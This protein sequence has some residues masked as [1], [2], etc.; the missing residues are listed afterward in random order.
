MTKVDNNLVRGKAVTSPLRLYQMKQAGINQ[1]IDLRNT[2]FVKRPIE[3]FF[4]KIF[5]IKYKNIK[6]PHRM[7]SIPKPDFFHSVISSIVENKGKTYIHCQYGKRRTGLCV[8]LYEK[9]R[10]NKPIDTIIKDMVKIGFTDIFDNPSSKRSKKYYGILKDF[11]KTYCF[12]K[13]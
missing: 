9:L 5:G 4:C 7:N 13:Q 3:K 8:A 1:I 12:P 10:T 6:Y 2:S 11:M